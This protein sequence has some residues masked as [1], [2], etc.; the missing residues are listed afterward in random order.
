L[1]LQ[2]HQI[3]LD[4]EHN[5]REERPWTKTNT[6][7]HKKPNQEYN[8]DCN[9][10]KHP[11]FYA[12]MQMKTVHPKHWLSVSFAAPGM[13]TASPRVQYNTIPPGRVTP[14]TRILFNVKY[15]THSFH[16]LYGIKRGILYLSGKSQQHPNK[17]GNFTSC[18]FIFLFFIFLQFFK[19]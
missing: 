19:K 6:L 12:I 14:A 8:A 3:T 15:T 10:K 17:G 11:L 9:T 4:N 2:K 16:I 7:H 1:V 13:V 18:N 5:G